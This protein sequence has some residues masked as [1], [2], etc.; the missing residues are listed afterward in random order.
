ML[1]EDK[2]VVELKAIEFILPVHE[3][4]LVT[5]LKLSGKRTGSLINFNFPFL[6]EGIRRR[7]NNYE[8]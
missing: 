6:K 2:I 4:Q 1:V 3:V 7:V 8:E 5:Y